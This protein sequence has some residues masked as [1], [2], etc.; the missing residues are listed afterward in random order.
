MSDTEGRITLTQGDRTMGFIAPNP[1]FNASINAGHDLQGKIQAANLSANPRLYANDSGAQFFHAETNSQDNS[2]LPTW[3]ILG[4]SLEALEQD[5]NVPIY[6]QVWIT[7]R[8]NFYD[9]AQALRL[10]ENGVSLDKALS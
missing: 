10:V 3:V 8:Q 4:D 9:V 7:E 2:D 6:L 5:P 1:S